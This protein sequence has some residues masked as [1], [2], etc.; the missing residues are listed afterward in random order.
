MTTAIQYTSIIGLCTA[1]LLS[2][3]L[4]PLLATDPTA[5]KIDALMQRQIESRRIPGASIAVVQ[6]GKLLFANGYGLANIELQVAATKNTVYE[7]ASVTKQFTAM[8]TMMLIEQGKLSLEDRV[9]TIVEG[10]PE[11]WSTI[12]IRHLLNHTSGIKSYT[13]IPNF[14][15]TAQ[16][17]YNGHPIIGLVADLPL[18]FAPGDKHNY[19]NTGYFLLGMV[20]EAVSGQTYG[21]FVAERIFQPLGMVSTHMNNRSLIIPDRADGYQLKGL[22]LQNATPVSPTQPYAA[23]GLVT[24]VL[25][26]AR[27]DKALNKKR[28]LKHSSYDA[29][30]TPAVLNDAQTHPYGFGWRLDPYRGQERLHH[31]GGIP[32]FSTYIEQFVKEDLAIIVLTNL[33]K[34]AADHIAH[35]IAELYLPVL[36][37]NGP[38]PIEDTASDITA[39]LRQVISAASHG[40]GKPEWFSEKWQ[41]FFLP[42]RVKEGKHMLGMFGELNSFKLMQDKVIKGR[43]MR[44]YEAEFGT[45]KINCSFKLT[46]DGKVDGISIKKQ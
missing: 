18:E 39:F 33:D 32:G 24:T 11:S 35:S 45:V 29:M 28:L 20:I 15:A 27:W 1:V 36:T 21:Q 23:G 31:S 12:N 3:G 13:S 2:L 34:A 10:L 17:D 38:Q 16:M 43:R 44:E 14:F 46:E 4:S 26:L 37:A 22:Q 40:E 42:D 19:S 30:W 7:L 25:D 9:T 41:K 8:A 5:K 6:E